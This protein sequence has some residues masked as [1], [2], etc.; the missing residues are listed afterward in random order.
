MGDSPSYKTKPTKDGLE[1]IWGKHLIL[2]KKE[3]HVDLIL[4]ICPQAH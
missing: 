3:P 1:N 4:L 2:P